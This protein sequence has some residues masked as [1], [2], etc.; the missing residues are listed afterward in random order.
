MDKWTD[1]VHAMTPHTN[2]TPEQQSTLLYQ[3]MAEV[4]R[5]KDRVTQLETTLATI[6]VTPQVPAPRVDNE[7]AAHHA[8]VEL[9]EYYQLMG[10]PTP[11][12]EFERV[13]VGRVDRFVASLTLPSGAVVK[14]E[15]P[16]TRKKTAKA[17]VASQALRLLGIKE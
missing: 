9:H 5:L 4:A 13:S 3:L 15:K 10:W 6:H 11:V 14:A 8:I 7:G 2:L 12:F 16:C 17:M 1:P